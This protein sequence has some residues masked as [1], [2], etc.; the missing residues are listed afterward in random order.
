MNLIN[1]YPKLLKRLNIESIFTNFVLITGMRKII[2]IFLYLLISYSCN[3]QSGNLQ[4]TYMRDINFQQIIPGVNKTI[5]ETDPNSGKFTITGNGSSNL[6]NVAFNL[7]QNIS[8]GS[9]SIPITYTATQSDNPND[10]QPGI[11]FD[12]YA[13]TTL[14]FSD[15]IREYYIKLGAKIYP[16][17]VQKA[18]D[19]SSPIIIILTTVSN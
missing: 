2:L 14:T 5:T 15:K 19:Y 7:S 4:I 17:Q 6:V 3:A 12:P 16:P 10:Y 13:G 1:K 18:G 11:P 8:S 9:G